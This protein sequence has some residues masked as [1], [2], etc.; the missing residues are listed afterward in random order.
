M[1][2]SYLTPILLVLIHIG[3]SLSAQE[4]L[5]RSADP[6]N[7]VLWKIEGNGISEPSYVLATMHL[8]CA[9]DYTLP[10]KVKRA[11]QSVD[12]LCLE[13]NITDADEIAYI[14]KHSMAN[15]KLS[16]TL[17]DEQISKLK[18][19]LP[20]KTG[21]T[22]EQLEVF[23]LAT[24]SSLA[25]IEAIACEN[26][27]SIES[28]LVSLAEVEEKPIIA[29]ETA[30]EQLEIIGDFI[31][32]DQLIESL[33]QSHLN[34]TAFERGTKL[35]LNEQVTGAT[36]ELMA[37]ADM[38]AGE[39][40]ALIYNRNKAWVIS[41]QDQMKSS[42]VLYAVGAGHLVDPKGLI[43]LLKQAGYALTPIFE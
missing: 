30:K 6:I 36:A 3:N 25:T 29:L 22:F 39:M 11:L 5:T 7:S 15:P 18:V 43:A 10:L 40:D 37:T 34:Q 21:M 24:I 27:I 14:Q 8:L 20:K 38:T 28:E 2:R 33:Q 9:D 12:S 32:V 26:P 31:T 13:M 4:L 41:M 17:S 42:A 23:T 19:L 35:Y 16:E 1:L